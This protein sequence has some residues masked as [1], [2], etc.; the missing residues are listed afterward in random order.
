VKSTQLLQPA[1]GN[2]PRM[3]IIW[4]RVHE[5]NNTPRPINVTKIGSVQRQEKIIT[6]CMAIGNMLSFLYHIRGIHNNTK[7][8]VCVMQGKRM[9]HYACT[10]AQ[11]YPCNTV[12]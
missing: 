10:I 8:N 2:P 11:N 9:R 7:M 1:L 12:V 3:K 4:S 6:C 5:K